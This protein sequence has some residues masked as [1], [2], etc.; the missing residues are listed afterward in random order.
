MIKLL[1]VTL[2]LLVLVVT[3]GCASTPHRAHYMPKGVK[4][5]PTC[6]WNGGCFMKLV[7]LGE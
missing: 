3:S 4:A 7:H 5:M 2:V 1:L 6:K